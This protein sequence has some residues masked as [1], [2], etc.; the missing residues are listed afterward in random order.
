MTVLLIVLWTVAV[1]AFWT[2]CGLVVAS[3]FG[4]ETDDTL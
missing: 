4:Q 1:L 2:A 3:M